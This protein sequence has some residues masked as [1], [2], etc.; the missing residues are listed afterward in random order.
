VVR[1]ILAE[2]EVTGHA[3]A[4]DQEVADLFVEK[5]GK[6]YLKNSKPATIR[7]EE[8]KPITLPAG[9]WEISGVKEYDHFLEESRR[10]QD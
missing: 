2:G 5:D 9:T 8:H 6:L 3:H 7:H 1:F 10:V 4:I